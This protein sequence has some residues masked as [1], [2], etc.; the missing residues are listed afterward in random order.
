[1]SYTLRIRD[2]GAYL[3]VT[4]EG[5]CTVENVSSYL[6][7]IIK[8]CHELHCPRVLIEQNLLGPDLNIIDVYTIVNKAIIMAAQ[9]VRQVAYVDLNP[10]HSEEISQFAENVAQNR[11]VNVKTFDNVRAAESWLNENVT[12][13]PSDVKRNH[14][15]TCQGNACCE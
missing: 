15:G 3:Q 13:P 12:P 10:E 2:Q 8:K 14:P 7:E 1:M 5:D 4:V 9:T 11:G 6:D